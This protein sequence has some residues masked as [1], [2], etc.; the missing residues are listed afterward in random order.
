MSDFIK[1]LPVNNNEFPNN[2]ENIILD[3]YFPNKKLIQL[4]SDIKQSI[5]ISIACIILILSR[6][7]Y[8]NHLPL[9]IFIPFSFII[10]FIIILLIIIYI[11]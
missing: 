5:L 11:F 3:I 7:F 6:E 1:N 8:F 9:S 10:I 2:E 4:F